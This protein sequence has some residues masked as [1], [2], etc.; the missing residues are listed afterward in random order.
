M[1][2]D[3]ACDQAELEGH[4]DQ[5]FLQSTEIPGVIRPKDLAGAVWSA[6]RKQGISNQLAGAMKCRLTASIDPIRLYPPEGPFRLSPKQIFRTRT[7]AQGE[8]RWVL[9]K[10]QGGRT[11]PVGDL[12]RQSF[13]L[14]PGLWVRNPA[15]LEDFAD[16]RAGR[17]HD[18]SA[19][20]VGPSPRR[21]ARD[22]QAIIAFE[23]GGA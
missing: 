16:R 11:S 23:F 1:A 14:L 13:L 17:G 5:H 20:G 22:L 15:K 19:K 12:V 10:Q 6:E 9:K 18:G 2:G 8:G 7:A 21:P 4:P 3:L